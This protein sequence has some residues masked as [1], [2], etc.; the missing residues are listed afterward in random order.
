MRINKRAYRLTSFA[1]LSDVPRQIIITLFRYFQLYFDIDASG[2]L[3]ASPADNFPFLKPHRPTLAC[4][5]WTQVARCY[6][7]DASR[8]ICRDA[9]FLLN[10]STIWPRYPGICPAV[11]WSQWV[12][13]VYVMSRG[14][15]AGGGGGALWRIKGLLWVTTTIS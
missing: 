4:S 15:A 11:L 6:L 12:S 5:P 1:V 10:L 9:G 14:R 8:M 7:V 13:V 3:Q 2:T